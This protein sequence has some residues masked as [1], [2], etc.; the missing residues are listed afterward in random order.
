MGQNKKLTKK[1]M[2]NA[3][4]LLLGLLVFMGCEK[5]ERLTGNSFSFEI[6][7]PAVT[8]IK[9]QAQTFTARVVAPSGAA[10]G[11][12]P[13]WSVI[14]ST[15]DFLNTHIG[16]SVSFTPTAL[17]DAVLVATYDGME[18]RSSVAVQVYKPDTTTFDVYTDVLP[19]GAGITADIF[20]SVGLVLSDSN[21]D[22]C[23]QGS[24]YQHTTNAISGNFWGVTLDKNNTS[25]FLDLSDFSG[26][27]LKF[28]IRLNRVLSGG[29]TII[30]NMWDLGFEGQITLTDQAQ[31][32]GTSRNWQDISLSLLSFQPN[33]IDFRQ[34]K[35]PFAIE[36]LTVFTPL[37]FDIDAIRWQ[38]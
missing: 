35:V 26:G 16:G 29:E 9:N 11:T 3:G 22:Y 37:S 34:V 1:I 33:P 24:K 5:K 10:S 6:T 4:L 17:G 21:S 36:T 31:F 20:T 27:S 23:P 30:V 25:Q 14:P 28:S 38:K 2:A 19:T 15:M 8:V 18:A 32:S 12:N 13:S 7:P